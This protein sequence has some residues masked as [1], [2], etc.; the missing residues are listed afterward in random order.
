[1]TDQAPDPRRQNTALIVLGLAVLLLL[2]TLLGF[3]L[4]GLGDD[5]E[6]S[7]STVPATVS[8]TIDDYCRLGW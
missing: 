7:D 3:V 2:G 6:P 4:G 8:T 5:E 1:M